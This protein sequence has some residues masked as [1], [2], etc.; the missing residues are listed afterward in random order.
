MIIEVKTWTSKEIE[1]DIDRPDKIEEKERS[2]IISY[3]TKLIYFIIN[4][5]SSSTL[6]LDQ[7]SW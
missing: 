3:R 5:N 4:R 2:Q 1:F 6:F 7:N